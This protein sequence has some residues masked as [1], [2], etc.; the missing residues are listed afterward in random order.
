[1]ILRSRSTWTRP[2]PIATECGGKALLGF[3]GALD[4]RVAGAGILEAGLGNVAAS[5]YVVDQ[6]DI[7]AYGAAAPKRNPAQ[8]GGARVDH[9]IVFDDGVA[10]QALFNLAVGVGGEA[11]GAQQTG[12]AHG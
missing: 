5:G 8:Y 6:P 12:R 9:D 11:L 4:S 10:R 1:M 7:A 2:S 3:G